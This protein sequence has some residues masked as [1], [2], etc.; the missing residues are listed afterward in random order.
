M[1]W[2]EYSP[3]L[4]YSFSFQ[5]KYD[6]SAFFALQP[7]IQEYIN[8]TAIKWGIK[9]QIRFSTDAESCEW[10]EETKRWRVRLRRRRANLPWALDD[11]TDEELQQEEKGDTWVH[12][13]K[14]LFSCVG[15]MMMPRKCETPGWENFKGDMFHSARWDHRV[16]HRGKDVIVIG[17]GCGLASSF[18][19]TY[20]LLTRLYIQVLRHSSS[21]LSFRR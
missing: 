8:Q 3:T 12:E 19:N 4:L 7:E 10:I 21:P 14:I 9:P 1:A 6:W 13:C 5:H 16:D 20:A 17:N 11:P 2:T 18:F 15:P